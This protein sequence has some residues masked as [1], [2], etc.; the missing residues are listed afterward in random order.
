M[1]PKSDNPLDPGQNPGYI[2]IYLPDGIIPLN[3]KSNV[4]EG[5]GTVQRERRIFDGTQNKNKSI[6]LAAQLRADAV[7]PAGHEP[8]GVCGYN[9]NSRC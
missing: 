7:A 6:E 4:S 8:A 2:A 5:W 9:A 3:E 1:F